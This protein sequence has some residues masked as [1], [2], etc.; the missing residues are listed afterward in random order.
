MGCNTSKSFDPVIEGSIN[1]SEKNISTSDSLHSM[2]SQGVQVLKSE[3]INL[4]RKEVSTNNNTSNSDNLRVRNSTSEKCSSTILT[5]NIGNDCQV[6]TDID[7]AELTPQITSTSYDEIF[8]QNLDTYSDRITFQSFLNLPQIKALLRSNQIKKITLKNVYKG[9]D[10]DS[11]GCLY[12]SEFIEIMKFVDN[13]FQ[14]VEITLEDIS[15][16]FISPE[17]NSVNNVMITFKSIYRY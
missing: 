9:F 14:H 6:R 13:S 7:S 3:E 5:V 4:I 10:K 1:N 16:T 2:V 8:I 17:K 11:D 15:D 12:Y